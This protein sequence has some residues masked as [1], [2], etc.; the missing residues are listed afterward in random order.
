MNDGTT[1]V[2]FAHKDVDEVV[3]T[4]EQAGLATRV[5]RLRLIGVLKG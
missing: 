3:A 4:C 1:G 5:A 2:P